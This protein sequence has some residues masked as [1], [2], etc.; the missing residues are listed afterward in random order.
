V[1]RAIKTV[2]VLGSGFGIVTVGARQMVRSVPMELS[3]DTMTVLSEAQA[4]G[5]VTPSAL[6]A[7][8]GWDRGRI[9][10][11]LVRPG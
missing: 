3:G 2:A 4:A 1:V 11:A 10:A 9:D 5:Y 7:K 8:L 6:A